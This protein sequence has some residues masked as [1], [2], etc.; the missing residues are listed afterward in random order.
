MKDIRERTETIKV[1]DKT[2]KEPDISR[3]M[4]LRLG[5]GLVKQRDRDTTGSTDT[6]P[7]TQAVEQTEGQAFGAVEGV[8]SFSKALV[9]YGRKQQRIKERKKAPAFEA[10]RADTSKDTDTEQIRPV[11]IKDKPAQA[12]SHGETPAPTPRPLKE[13]MRQSAIKDRQSQRMEIRQR[14][15]TP[16]ERP[17]SMPLRKKT[18]G[19]NTLPKIAPPT[20]Q[21]RMKQKAVSEL[22]ARRI[23]DRRI[24]DTP[25]AE[26]TELPIHSND[27]KTLY[28][29]SRNTTAPA[30]KERPR[31]S[32][33]VKD[34]SASAAAVPK[35]RKTAPAKKPSPKAFT[36]PREQ[37]RRR[38]QRNAQRKLLRQSSG[39][40]KTTA[41]F[42]RK[43]VAA[44]GKA[45]SA[46]ISAIAGLLGSTVLVAVICVLVVIGGIM[47]SPF[48][49]L[50][51]NEPSPNAMPLNV[52]IG[53]LNME[54]SNVLEDL[55]DGDYDGIDVQGQGPDWREVVAVFAVK[56]AGVSDGVD[57]A[58]LTSDRFERLRAVFWD[59]CLVESWVESI[60]HGDSDPDDGV[61]DRWTEY[62]LHITITAKTAEDM[63]A[64]YDF[65]ENQNGA[66][67][68]L[69]DE[70]EAMELLITDLSSCNEQ[71]R[72][73]LK[74]LPSDLSPER[75]TVVET[76][77]TLVGKVSY[78]WGGKS[79]VIG[80][81]SRWGTIRKVTSPGSYTMGTYLPYGLD[82][83]GFVDWVFYN[84]S[85]GDYII[86]HG[87]GAQ[88][89]HRYCEDISWDEAQPGDLV[90]Y[91]RDSHVGIVG[92]RDGDGELLIVHCASGVVITGADGFVSIGRPVF[93]VE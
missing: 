66:L 81:D 49:I 43:A 80:W 82:C 67:T 46:G 53:N 3:Q 68:E 51:S 65:T 4:M 23:R 92:G 75:R 14:T 12:V 11:T 45:V 40:A 28:P 35:T 63:R 6:V 64:E 13:R 10:P 20:P 15:D 90:F 59:M 37:A 38:V 87:G 42:A 47:A 29:D 21:E 56:T 69:L 61:D 41:G 89:Q 17:S 58:A 62:I 30:I 48:G 70:L 31:R 78:F 86:G 91:P 77:C 7:E 76:A 25:R 39:K 27:I 8:R 22:R 71:A 32:F 50:F 88:A 74:G 73:L 24:A 44:V 52:A 33:S 36:L 34:K 60:E 18:E 57:V 84:V 26:P 55:Q 93:F 2:R 19:K 16:K 72:E 1:K 79:C 9:R 54:L 5:R 83:S 85:D